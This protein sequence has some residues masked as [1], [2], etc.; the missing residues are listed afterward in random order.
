MTSTRARHMHRRTVK[1]RRIVLPARVG[2]VRIVVIAA[3]G[4][5]LTA[6]WLY[7]RERPFPT[8]AIPR[9]ERGDQFV[10]SDTCRTCHPEAH[11]SWR[12]T[13]HST[14]TQVVSPETV[15]AD[16]DDREYLADG[17]SYRFSRQGD[18][19]LVYASKPGIDGRLWPLPGFPKPVVMSTGSHHYQLF[20]VATNRKTEP[21]EIPIYY[22]IAEQRWIPKQQ[23]VLEP[24]GTPGNSA[25][26]NSHCINCHSVNGIPRFNNE[27]QR[28]DSSVAEFGISC[29]S[30]HGPGGEH[31][32]HHQ[33]IWNRYS[34]RLSDE[35]DTTII[36]P[37][38]CSKIRSVQ[39]C[40]RCHHNG[41]PRDREGSWE[42]GI[43]FRPGSEDLHD[44][45][46]LSDFDHPPDEPNDVFE[47]LFWKDGTC[48][49]AGDEYN[50]HIKSPCYLQGELTCLSCHSLHDSDSNDQ[51]AKGMET[52][53]ACLQCH[54]SF[55]D[56][57]EEHTHHAAD[58][59]GSL[60][61]NCH[62]PHSSYA[63][64][65]AIRSHTIG[66]PSA[67]VSAQTGRP[68]A[69]NLCHLDKT[70]KWTSDYLTEW[71]GEPPAQLDLEQE[72]IAASLLWLLKGDALQRSLAAWHMGWDEALNISGND[73][74]APFLAQLLVDP[75]AQPRFIAHRSL[76][77]LPGYHNFEYDFLEPEPQLN[78]K[79]QEVLTIWQ[80]IQTPQDSRRERIL[81]I[82]GDEPMDTLRKRLTNARDEKPVSIPE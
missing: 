35:P 8:G 41:T 47:N 25:H 1:R 44:Y 45:F 40:G 46:A 77:K 53:E 29:E 10:S 20:W 12:G 15:V 62:M 7:A 67:E 78:T 26:W 75:Y 61:Y 4:A 34:Q 2:T 55:R 81:D 13:Y 64:S 70:L 31:V 30:C 16:F 74:Q 36:N 14:M 21:I 52:N 80:A 65:T 39:I 17:I 23:T 18:Q 3:L 11:D 48:R 37:A 43:G 66:S 68:N 71:Y 56:R 28:A 6:W 50:A 42:H 33:N 24:P 60:C 19:F 32:R 54:T 38:R 57:V 27:R 59:S 82:T 9:I 5:S 69:C 63:L 58:S 73:W 49:I 76:R 79:H 51:L 72:R 22:H